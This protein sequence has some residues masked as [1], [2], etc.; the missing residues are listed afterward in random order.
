MS[1]TDNLSAT[2]KEIKNMIESF[3]D[4]TDLE[5][6]IIFIDSIY[7][8]VSSIVSRR[9]TRTSSLLFTLYSVVESLN[10]YKGLVLADDRSIPHED[11]VNM[12]IGKCD[13]FIRIVID[14]EDKIP[15]TYQQLGEISELFKELSLL[16]KKE[17][18]ETDKY[19]YLKQKQN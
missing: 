2:E 5:L 15:Y 6:E 11:F 13:N 9:E 18:I 14:N 3:S 12:I 19:S 1:S 16:Q 7:K 8:T 10:K 17:L 4:M